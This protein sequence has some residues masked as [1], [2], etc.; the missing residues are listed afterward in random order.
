MKKVFIS[1]GLLCIVY[2][3]SAQQKP[4]PNDTETKEINM[5]E[6]ILSTK[7]ICEKKKYAFDT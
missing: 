6:E 1:L 5:K 4:N 3:G 2:C 7:N